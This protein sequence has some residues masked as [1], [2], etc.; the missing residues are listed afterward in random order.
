MINAYLYGNKCNLVKLDG[1]LKE[2]YKERR[3]AHTARTGELRTN[4]LTGVHSTVTVNL[5][6]KG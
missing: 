1:Y 4:A 5:C 3:V 6:L 2:T